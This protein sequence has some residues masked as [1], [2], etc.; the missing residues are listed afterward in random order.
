MQIWDKKI[1]IIFLKIIGFCKFNTNNNNINIYRNKLLNYF[2]LINN[3][4]LDFKNDV[5]NKRIH[6][7]NYI[8]NLWLLKITVL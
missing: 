8:D 7:K 1:L 2:A 3:I 5:I 6:L 4:N